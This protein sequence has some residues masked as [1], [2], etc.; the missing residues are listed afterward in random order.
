[1]PQD[2]HSKTC[3][4]CGYSAIEDHNFNTLS[5][6]YSPTEDAHYAECACGRYG[7]TDHYAYSYAKN[8]ISLHHVY[9]ECGQ[10]IGSAPHVL[11]VGAAKIKFCIHCNQRVNTEDIVIRPY[12]APEEI[13]YITDAGSYVG[14]DGNIYL[15]E[16]DMALYLAGELDVYALVESLNAYPTV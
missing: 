10:L 16:S 2:N 3:L 14:P 4:G 15:V 13:R 8:N 1:M 5:S 6:I 9:C 12:D 7:W 11:P